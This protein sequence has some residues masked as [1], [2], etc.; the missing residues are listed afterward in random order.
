MTAIQQMIA[1]ADHR[2]PLIIGKIGSTAEALAHGAHVTRQRADDK[3]HR[4]RAFGPNK[5][6]V[7]RIA[8]PN[9][10]YRFR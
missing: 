10:P 6:R 7:H 1:K 8:G 9:G 3:C 5:T 2:F 4:C